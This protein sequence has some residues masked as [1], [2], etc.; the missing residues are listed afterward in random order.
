M[1]VP[2]PSLGQFSKVLRDIE[3]VFP[4]SQ[5]GTLRKKIVCTKKSYEIDSITSICIWRSQ[6]LKL[7]RNTEGFILVQF[8]TSFIEEYMNFPIFGHIFGNPQHLNTI[9]FT[10]DA[11][12]IIHAEICLWIS[13]F[14]YI[15]N[16]NEVDK[17]L[18]FRRRVTS[19]GLIKKTFLDRSQ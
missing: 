2:H 7:Q 12:M 15:M 6:F 5:S 11:A 13:S 8:V 9:T 17:F 14:S 16:F 3:D 4:S 19:Q 1:F 10:L 18:C